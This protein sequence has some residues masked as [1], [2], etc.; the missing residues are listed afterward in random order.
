MSAS[1]CLADI[2]VTV[3]DIN[4]VE[5][6][7]TGSPFASGDP[8]NISTQ[9]LAEKAR[10]VVNPWYS[11]SFVRIYDTNALN[12]GTPTDTVGDVTID[13]DSALPSQ[14]R[15]LVAPP[16]IAG[17]N[18]VE[19]FATNP[20]VPISFPGAKH[21][22][23][24]NINGTL[25]Q[26]V[27]VAIAVTGDIADPTHT[28]PRDKVH[29]A[30]IYRV[31]TSGIL[32]G[33]GNIVSGGNIYADLV[34]EMNADKFASGVGFLQYAVANVWAGQSIQGNI[35]A[36]GD[37][38]EGADVRNSIGKVIVG[39]NPVLTGGAVVGIRGDIK[40]ERGVIGS[41]L[42]NGPIGTALDKVQIRAGTGITEIR[43]VELDGSG[44]N[45][46]PAA[47]NI[48]ADI[49][50]NLDPILMSGDGVLQLAK[51]SYVQTDGD[52]EG[53]I[54]ATNLTGVN[55]FGSSGILV[56]GVLDAPVVI[57]RSVDRACIIASTFT[58]PIEIGLSLEGVVVATDEEEGEIPEITIGRLVTSDPELADV[59]RG[60]A[61]IAVSPLSPDASGPLD[62]FTADDWLTP[63]SGGG[64]GADFHGGAPDCVIRAH[65]IGTAS[66]GTISTAY[67][68]QAR[69][70]YPPRIEADVID[71]VLVDD[72]REGAIWS[73]NLE[74]ESGELANDPTNDY[75]SVGELW[76]GNVG[77]YA[78]VWFQDCPLAEFT[79]D[80]LGELRVPTLQSSEIIQI[81]GS[82]LTYGD[83]DCGYSWVSGECE[84]P[85]SS[86]GCEESPRSPGDDSSCTNACAQPAA[87]RIREANG[88]AG[89]IILNAGN[90]V[91][92]P[93]DSWDGV[94][95]VGD[96]GVATPIVFGPDESQPLE[97]PYYNEVPSAFGDGAIGVGP[98]HVHEAAC[99]PVNNFDDPEHAIPESAFVDNGPPDNFPI[100]IRFYGPVE[101]YGDIDIAD[102]LTVEMQ[103]P[104][105]TT[106]GWIATPGVFNAVLLD[107]DRTIGLYADNPAIMPKPGT[108]RIYA[109]PYLLMS[110][111]V[112]A[113]PMLDDS[114]R[115]VIW[116]DIP[117]CS[118]GET[119]YLVRVGRDCDLNGVIDDFQDPPPVCGGCDADFD[120]DTDVDVADLF[121]FL[122]AW[123]AQFPSGTPGSPS[124]D[125]DGNLTVEVADLFNFLDDWF[126]AFGNCGA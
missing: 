67:S 89:Q 86:G 68:G 15:V 33:S 76:I 101:T 51:L 110:A 58:E 34:A 27:R 118:G 3:R 99:V 106:C 56:R 113:A 24:L 98:Y 85:R 126:P 57:D 97:G 14:I 43:C 69:K 50:T 95:I 55:V 78:D 19:D 39:I 60:M 108:Y 124:A 42:C 25:P 62:E 63:G 112:A 37:R 82:L 17:V 104:G 114:S 115:G 5:Q 70:E 54:T 61:G 44:F 90:L 88:L 26:I 49:V 65:H 21:F 75:A 79:G 38:A 10:S 36:T 52:F 1:S 93:E 116:P 11:Y 92:P 111:G 18:G 47:E 80:V 46:G 120:N 12:G 105:S 117:F 35:E 23:S 59:P 102:A 91:D 122:D 66:I 121:G 100:K 77:P 20:N 29:A 83:C 123:F 71:S 53:S 9:D 94:V 125:Y 40:A 119:G 31:Q 81:D 84:Y 41:I 73:G 72:F 16:L 22:R 109:D 6:P 87:V 96:D 107:K 32:D 74:F 45:S 7:I 103:A 2:V 13:A 8:I 64:Q 48:Y 4:G 30:Q 28:S